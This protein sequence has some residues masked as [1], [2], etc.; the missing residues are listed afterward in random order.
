M[1]VIIGMDP[2]E[3]SATIEVID[4]V[5]RAV[6]LGRFGTDKEATPTAREGAWT[7]TPTPA[8]PTARLPG[9]GLIAHAVRQIGK[10]GVVEARQ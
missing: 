1:G 4:E 10:S 9:L 7:T 3:R 2:H 5:G 8:R 6:A